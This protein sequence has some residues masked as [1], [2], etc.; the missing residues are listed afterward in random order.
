MNQRN[1]DYRFKL[2][3]AQRKADYRF[4]LRATIFVTAYIVAVSTVIACK[5]F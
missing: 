1:D 4:K 5:F 3:M 2:D